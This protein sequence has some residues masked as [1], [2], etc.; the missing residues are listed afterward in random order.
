MNGATFGNANVRMKER[1][2]P[3]SL[4]QQYAGIVFGLLVNI[5]RLG[6][7]EIFSYSLTFL[8]DSLSPHTYVL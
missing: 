2:S 4:P 7:I 5:D 8:G 6:R 1:F 3:F